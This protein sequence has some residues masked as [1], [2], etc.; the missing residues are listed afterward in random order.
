[1]FVN[2]TEKEVAEEMKNLERGRSILDTVLGDAKAL[3][4]TLGARARN[5]TNTLPPCGNLKP[6]YSRINS[7][8]NAQS[9]SFLTCVTDWHMLSHH[10]RDENKIEELARIEAAEFSTNFFADLLDQTSVTLLHTSC[11][12]CLLAVVTNIPEKQH[13]VCQPLRPPRPT[14]GR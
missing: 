2:G 1:M 6:V 8:Q 13:A 10:G 5:L 11:P 14:H 3:N 7:G 4:V 12:F 9:L